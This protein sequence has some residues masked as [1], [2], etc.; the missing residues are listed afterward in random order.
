LVSHGNLFWPI[1]AAVVVWLGVVLYWLHCV[2]DLKEKTEITQ[3][4]SQNT[5]IMSAEDFAIKDYEL[6]IRYLTDHLGR[7]WTRFN[8]FLTLQTGLAGAKIIYKSDD[9]LAIDKNLLI[10]ALILAVIWCIVGIIDSGLVRNY[11]AHVKLVFEKLKP[12]L[13]G[14]PFSDIPYTGEVEEEKMNAFE[15]IL[16]K[17]FRPTKLVYTVPLILIFTL[18][19]TLLST[20]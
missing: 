13:T 3:H 4:H 2:K 11:R 20:Q 12:A 8:I 19:I 16:R 1:G 5:N 15:R 18:L 14:T 10:L 17:G 7:M 9:K 6:K